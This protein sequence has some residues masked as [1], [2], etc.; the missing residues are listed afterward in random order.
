MLK[1]KTCLLFLAFLIGAEALTCYYGK[2]RVFPKT[3]AIFAGLNL[4]MTKRQVEC[5]PS[6]KFCTKLKMDSGLEMG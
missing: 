4:P 6:A 2:F 3:F 1:F 5:E